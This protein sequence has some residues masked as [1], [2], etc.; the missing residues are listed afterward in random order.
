MPVLPCQ[1]IITRIL[2]HFQAHN[3]ISSSAH[4]LYKQHECI[5]VA[6]TLKEVAD[7]AACAGITASKK[8]QGSKSTS[9]NKNSSNNALTKKA[10]GRCYLTLTKV[11][12][13]R[14]SAV[15]RRAS[16][17]CC[18]CCCCF[19]WGA[20]AHVQFLSYTHRSDR[21]CPS[22]INSSQTNGVCRTLASLARAPTLPLQSPARQNMCTAS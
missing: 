7:A 9:S 17:C 1:S 8:T 4:H 15:P 11:I 19:F 20:Y 21:S 16:F 12:D 22:V 10:I 5:G 3:I 6:R 18:F 14:P 2:F 13:C